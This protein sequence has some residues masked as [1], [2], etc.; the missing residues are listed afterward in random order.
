MSSS[1]KVAGP[2]APTTGDG[3]TRALRRLYVVRFGFALVWAALLAAAGSELTAPSV[4]LLVLYP[5]FDVAAAVIDHRSTGP[6]SR[7]GPVTLALYLT[8]AL[9]LL[10]TAGVA[11]AA[12][13]SVGDVLRV[14]GAWAI[15]A[16]AVQ[17]VVGLRRRGIGGQWAMIL[18]GGISTLAGVAFIA[19][20]ARPDPSL[21][22]LA[23]YATLGGVFFLVSALRLGR[24][25]ARHDRPSGT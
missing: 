5:L 22:S 9:S 25:P 24:G 15:S 8:M 4:T 23:G 18:S 14:W 7:R 3:G 21:A 11:I 6:G 13:D 16:G 10:A 12:A 2:A 17:L 1:I 19:M 20:A